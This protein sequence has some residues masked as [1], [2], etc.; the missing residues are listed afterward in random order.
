MS[1]AREQA[2]S[3]AP[4]DRLASWQDRAERSLVAAGYR[5]GGARR[6]VLLLLS[7]QP[8][9][10][11]ATEIEQALESAGRSSRRSQ[12]ARTPAKRPASRASIYRI[13]DELERLG[14]VQRIATGGTMVR[15][16]R[17]RDGAGHHHHLVCEDCGVVQ[18]FSDQSLEQTIEELSERV[19]LAVSEHE[20]V[21]RGRC[22][23]CAG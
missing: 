16:E 12:R 22:A 5:R 18:P 21:L 19:P 10:L 13:L 1:P 2:T 7:S 23:A 15:F 9:A 4:I 14:L 3:A 11:T 8:C 20:I 17:A 6:A